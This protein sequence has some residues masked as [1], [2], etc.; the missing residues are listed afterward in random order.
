MAHPPVVP[1]FVSHLNRVS[2]DRTYVL[3][4]KRNFFVIR[5]KH[6]RRRFRKSAVKQALEHCICYLGTVPA[7]YFPEL[8][9]FDT[10]SDTD[11]DITG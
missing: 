1:S 11:G 5:H 2:E 9:K 6:N 7:E 4:F 10:D 8:D 3:D